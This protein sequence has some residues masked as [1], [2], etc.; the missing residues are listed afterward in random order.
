MQTLLLTLL[1]LAV[2]S[3][4]PP[5]FDEWQSQLE[6]FRANRERQLR[7]PDGWLAVSGLY[8]LKEGRAT[9]G[10]A[11]NCDIVLRASAVPA[12]AGTLRLKNGVLS[13]EA[14][15]GTRLLKNKAVTDSGTLSLEDPAAEAD[16]PDRLEIGSVSLQLLRRAGRLAIRSRD[17]EHPRIAAFPGERWFA[18]NPAWN[19][20]ARFTPAGADA[21]VEIQNVR[22]QSLSQPLAGTVEFDYGGQTWKLAALADTPETLFIIFRDQTSG[23]QSWPGGRFLSL[24]K[25]TGNTLNLDFNRAYNPPCAYNP[26]TLCPLPPKSNTLPLPITAGALRPQDDPKE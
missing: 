12:L 4:L 6:A 3:M 22:G 16:S 17:N 5:V 10:S 13:F 20:A 8:W 15:P 26:H 14:A 23:Q 7:S 2:T 9:F 24:P 21:E 11:A 19:L 18:P 25:P 1:P